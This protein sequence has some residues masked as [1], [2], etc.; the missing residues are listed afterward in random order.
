[1]E[2][3][4]CRGARTGELRVEVRSGAGTNTAAQDTTGNTRPIVDNG[5]SGTA[6]RSSCSACF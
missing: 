1:M 5:T 3:A 4:D 6:Q 2:K